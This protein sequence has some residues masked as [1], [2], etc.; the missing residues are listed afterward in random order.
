ME[1]A[2]NRMVLA[3]FASAVEK[4]PARALRKPAIS[5]PSQLHRTNEVRTSLLLQRWRSR[6]PSRAKSQLSLGSINSPD[7]NKARSRDGAPH[8]KRSRIHDI[9][10]TLM[11]LTRLAVG[12]EPLNALDAAHRSPRFVRNF[13]AGIGS[14]VD[15]A[16]AGPLSETKN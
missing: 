6:L 16:L 14:P 13:P 7:S 11:L 8:F 10:C 3:E 12:L 1:M 5:G 2:A 9:P 4:R 15:P